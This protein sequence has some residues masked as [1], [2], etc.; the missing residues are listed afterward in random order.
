MSTMDLSTLKRF[1]AP[2][3]PADVCGLCSTPVGPT[4]AHLFDRVRQALDCACAPCAL[5]L[6]QNPKARWVLVPHRAERLPESPIGAAEWES[7]GV[8]IGLAFFV[9]SSTEGAVTAW[10]PG[11]AG[12]V[13]CRLT[14]EPP[15]LDLA[16]DVEAL[17]VT[18]LYGASAAY[19]LSIDE[20]FALVGLIRSKWHG[21]TGGGVVRDAVTEFLA[22]IDRDGAPHA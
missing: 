4:H 17:L 22:R 3:P 18:R 15:R 11:P 1:V 21:F 20:C 16:E 2:R 19:R 13:R 8:P 6:E 5:V 12:A 10:Y 9:R 14:F 7:L